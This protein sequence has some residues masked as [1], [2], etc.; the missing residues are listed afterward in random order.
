MT[1]FLTT[2]SLTPAQSYQVALLVTTPL[3]PSIHIWTVGIKKQLESLT[4]ANNSTQW[5]PN[6]ISQ[7]T[8]LGI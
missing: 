7:V 5:H 8:S 3:R 6:S 2:T 4:G 1:S